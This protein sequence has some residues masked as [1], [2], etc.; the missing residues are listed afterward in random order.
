M[1]PAQEWQ[2]GRDE[3]KFSSGNKVQVIA[4]EEIGKIIACGTDNDKIVYMI[5]IPGQSTCISV[6]Q[7]EIKS[8]P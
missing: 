3:F 1:N 4:T 5:K 6:F 8:C 2:R 7:D